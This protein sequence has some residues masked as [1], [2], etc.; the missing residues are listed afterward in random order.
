MDRLNVAIAEC[1]GVEQKRLQNLLN[2]LTKDCMPPLEEPESDSN[3]PE[4]SHRTSNAN[5]SVGGRRTGSLASVNQ[6]VDLI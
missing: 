2:N 4:Q 5:S 1:I 6:S 3:E